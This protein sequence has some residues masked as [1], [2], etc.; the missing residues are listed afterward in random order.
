MTP[1]RRAMPGL[2][3]ISEGRRTTLFLKKSQ[4]SYTS[5]TTPLLNVSEQP[6]ANK[7]LPFCIMSITASCMTSVYTSKRGIPALLPIA[8]KTA[9]AMLPTPD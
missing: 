5:C 6:L 9:L 3:E 2:L 1:N 4:L 8:A 7:I